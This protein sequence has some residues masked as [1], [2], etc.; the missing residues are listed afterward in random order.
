MGRSPHLIL[1]FSHTSTPQ[2]RR[3]R[4][5]DTEVKADGLRPVR[6]RDRDHV[7]ALDAREVVGIA[8]IDREAVGESRR[9]DQ[10]IVGAHGRSP[11]CSTERGGD[12]AEGPCRARVESE[13]VEI[14]FG[15]LK[16]RLSRDALFVGGRDQ[17]PTDNSA[18]VIAVI[19]GPTGS[20][21][22][23]SI[24][25]KGRRVLVSSTPHS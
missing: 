18:R 14:R 6:D 7:Q 20:N 24:W 15:L 13:G 2:A 4:E 23:S 22:G 3:R 16:V 8:G 25:G 11:S 12:P 21:S 10:R 9:G 5:V 19:N 1:G 17:G